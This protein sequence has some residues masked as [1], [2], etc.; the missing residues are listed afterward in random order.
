M[1]VKVESLKGKK[2]GLYFSASWCGPCRRFTPK[3]VEVYNELLPK[4]DF[5]IVFVS[6]DEDDESFAA[7]FSK[8]PW[9]AIPFSD[10]ETRDRLDELFSVRG[11][12]HLVIIGENG[13]VSTDDG[14]EVVQG[15]GA[16]GYPFS[17]EWI[18]EIKE[19]EEVARRNQTLK[20][21][22]VSRSRDYVVASDGKKVI[23]IFSFENICV[24]V[25][26]TLLRM[27]LVL[28]CALI[29]LRC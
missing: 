25:L 27:S 26:A 7:Y 23:V 14:V 6:A 21:I 10:S 5:E 15:C 2:V 11:I 9:L 18:K 22:L 1:Q 17:P 8:M 29:G 24:P 16:E 13:K 4:D 19:Q 3:L 20:T 28:I 12:P